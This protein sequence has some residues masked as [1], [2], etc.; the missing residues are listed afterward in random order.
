MLPHEGLEMLYAGVERQFQTK[1][2]KAFHR[3]VAIYPNGIT[4]ELNDGRKGVVV[5]Q[6]ASFSDRPIVRI[7]EE[8]GHQI[9]PYEINLEKELSIVVTGCDTTFKKG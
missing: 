8:N 6:N 1:I 9:N 7:L 2:I 3:S 5:Q 4:V